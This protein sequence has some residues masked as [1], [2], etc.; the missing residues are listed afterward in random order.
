MMSVERVGEEGLC[1]IER[2]MPRK[3]EPAA[4]GEDA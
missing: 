4:A 2:D 1:E 3:L